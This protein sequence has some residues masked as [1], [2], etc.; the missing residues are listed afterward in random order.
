L[1]SFGFGKIFYCTLVIPANEA[2]SQ[3]AKL[4]ML[5][6]CHSGLDPWFDRL[7]TLS[8]VEG[9]SSAVSGRYVSGCPR[10]AMRYKLLKSSMTG[11]IQAFF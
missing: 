4:H 5:L 11:R 8:K 1:I 9:E 7:T 2:V 10:I 6:F 3:L